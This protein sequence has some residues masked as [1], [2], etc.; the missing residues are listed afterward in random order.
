MVIQNET[1]I[2]KLIRYIPTIIVAAIC[3][4]VTY[5]ILL[6]REE[7]F[8][9]E[10]K[11][12]R[13]TFIKYN[14]E[15]IVNEVNSIHSYISYEK[16]NSELNLKE[17]IKNRVDE[18]HKT[19]SYI[20]KTYKDILTKEEITTKIKD[21]IYSQRFNNGRGY[22]YIYDLQGYNIIH[23]IQREIESKNM[24]DFQDYK[25][26][27]ITKEIIKELQLS[28]EIFYKLYWNKPDE[29][30][31]FEKITYNKKFE[32]YS[33]F[34]GSGEYVCEFENELKTKI[35]NY[36][37]TIKY[38]K[39]GYVFIIDYEGNYLSHIKKEY[40]GLNRI[41]LVD[42]NG[43]YITKE[44]IKKAKEGSGFISYIGTI[45]PQTNLPASKT[46]FVMG[47]E[48]WNWAIATGFYTDELEKQIEYVKKQKHIKNEE[49]VLT[50]IVINTSITI[51][52]LIF[53]L[54]ISHILKLRFQDYK[55]ELISLI[56]TNRQKDSLLSQQSKMAAMG[57][58]IQSIAHQWR[59]P[60]SYISTIATAIKVQKEIGVL[61]ETELVKN[62]DNISNSTKYLSQTI[63]DFRE[64]FSPQ[65][66]VTNFKI[67]DTICK[68]LKIIEHQF[69][70]KKIKIIKNIE[71]I[72]MFGFE[73]E[74]VQV[75]INILNNAKD[76]FENNT[77]ILNKVIIIEAKK[78]EEKVYISFK[79]NAGGFE[80]EL[81]EKIFDAYFTTKHE[82]NGTGIGLYISKQIIEKNFKGKLLAKNIQLDF[83]NNLFSGACFEIILPLDAL[84]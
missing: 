9:E 69:N 18:I 71:D 38:S 20:H 53:S 63:E 57:E 47:F 83:E 75:V 39:N 7:Q 59:Q 44:I 25:G 50:L 30:G 74:L 11:N 22:F 81:E 37:N 58:M 12:I 43:V 82:S 54:F 46:S 1:F 42:K 77:Q 60:L 15:R 31:T 26:K 65:K 27:F 34:I 4:L 49:E 61:D 48:P 45:K 52:F 73:N 51:V 24:I 68:T 40:I 41:N 32:P 79:D 2:L 29:K 62:M 5:L 78:I 6:Q 21:Y 13:Q 16:Q 84:N 10:L 33:W 28:N 23:P 35:L 76:Q 72:Q 8:K 66:Q 19:I 67:D 36:I 3:I 17:N 64:F 14:E 55:K 70:S 56:E 80:K